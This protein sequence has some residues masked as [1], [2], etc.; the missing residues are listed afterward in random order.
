MGATLG[1]DL[2]DLAKQV[3]PPLLLDRITERSLNAGSS[4]L[5]QFAKDGLLKGRSDTELSGSISASGSGEG[6]FDVVSVL[7]NPFA[8]SGFALRVGL[9]NDAPL[10]EPSRRAT[11]LT[12]SSPR[13]LNLSLLKRTSAWSLKCAF[14][15]LTDFDLGSGEVRVRRSVLAHILDRSLTRLNDV[16]GL[17]VHR[18]RSPERQIDHRQRNGCRGFV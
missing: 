2:T 5:D 16:A 18:T 15:Q 1:S 11:A 14:D 6:L 13:R 9:A 4:A 12:S 10:E 3:D 7:I 17:D 8:G